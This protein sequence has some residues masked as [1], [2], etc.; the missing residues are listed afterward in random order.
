MGLLTEKGGAQI[1]LRRRLNGDGFD[2]FLEA[3][4]TIYLE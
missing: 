3:G 1:V 4:I 2:Q